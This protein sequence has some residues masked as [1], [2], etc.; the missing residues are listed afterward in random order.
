MIF[1]IM[2]TKLTFELKEGR[3]GFAQ[4]GFHVLQISE[5]AGLANELAVEGQR[6][7]EVQQHSIVDGQAQHQTHQHELIFVLQAA[8]VE[9][10]RASLLQWSP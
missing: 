7:G 3:E 6:Q 1:I 9:P 5:G 10:V 8:W 4:G 2:F